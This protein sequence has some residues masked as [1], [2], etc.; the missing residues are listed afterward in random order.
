MAKREMGVRQLHAHNAQDY[1]LP[2]EVQ[3]EAWS[4]LT[5]GPVEGTSPFN[6][7]VS[8]SDPKLWSENST[9]F[10]GK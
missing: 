6:S 2:P 5:L 4:R 3:R 1:Q 8:D 10:K 7:L 9:F